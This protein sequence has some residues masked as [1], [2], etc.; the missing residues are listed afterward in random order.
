MQTHSQI[1]IE[2]L[3]AMIVILIV[4]KIMT[5]FALNAIG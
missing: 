1:R 2:I 3:P 5:V 4:Y